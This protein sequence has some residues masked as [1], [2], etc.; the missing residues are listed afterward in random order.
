MFFLRYWFNGILLFKPEFEVYIWNLRLFWCDRSE[1]L[2]LLLI[3]SDFPS[4]QWL[5][6]ILVTLDYGFQK[7]EKTEELLF[8]G[9]SQNAHACVNIYRNYYECGCA[10]VAIPY[11]LYWKINFC[12]GIFGIKK[13]WARVRQTELLHF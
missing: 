3:A 4:F 1:F 12:M 5:D 11:L 8:S 10:V 2:M 7:R 9:N 6:E 13:V